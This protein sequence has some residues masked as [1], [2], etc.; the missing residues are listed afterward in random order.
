MREIIKILIFQHADFYIFSILNVKSFLMKLKLAAHMHKNYL[1]S[2][3]KE[4]KIQKRKKNVRMQ[5]LYA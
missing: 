5:K 2:F 4:K 1:C 3:I